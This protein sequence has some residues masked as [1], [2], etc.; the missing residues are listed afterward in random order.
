VTAL[1]LE[2]R[3]LSCFTSQQSRWKE[4]TRLALRHS[5]PVRSTVLVSSHCLALRHSCQ[6]RS[7]MVKLFYGTAIKLEAGYYT[8]FTSQLSSRKHSTSHITSSCFTSQPSGRKQG[9]RPVLRHN[10]QVGSKILDW[11]YVSAIQPK[12]QY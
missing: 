10:H 6:A 8:G 9:T 2:A 11:L 1:K 4:D 3:Y 7:K 5:Y 12:A